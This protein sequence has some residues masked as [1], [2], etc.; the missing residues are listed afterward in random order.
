MKRTTLFCF[1]ALFSYSA[2]SQ[3]DMATGNLAT[4]TVYSVHGRLSAGFVESFKSGTPFFDNEW[5]NSTIVLADGKE[6]KN[7][8]TKINL[9][10]AEVYYKDQTNEYVSDSPIKEIIVFDESHKEKYRFTNFLY[11]NLADKKQADG[12]YILEVNGPAG[13]YRRVEKVI[14]ESKQYGSATTERS[15]KTN[16]TFYIYQNSTLTEIKRLK[17]V[18]NILVDKRVELEDYARTEKLQ[19]STAEVYRKLI[20]YY[21]GLVSEQ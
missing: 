13:L 14:E 16:N 12:W 5:T 2:Y 17:D 9:L 15:I 8:K 3:M 20:N 19:K 1:V 10:T 6:V 7:I 11:V 18:Y 21:N 4:N